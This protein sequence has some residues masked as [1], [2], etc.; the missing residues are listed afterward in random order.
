MKNSNKGKQAAWGRQPRAVS[1]H[2]TS[3][4]FRVGRRADTPAED[5]HRCESARACP[6][7]AAAPPLQ[8]LQQPGRHSPATDVVAID[9]SWHCRASLSPAGMTSAPRAAGVMAPIG[10]A[11][12]SAEHQGCCLAHAQGHM[13]LWTACAAGPAIALA[14]QVCGEA[15]ATVRARTE[16]G[17]DALFRAGAEAA[18]SAAMDAATS[19]LAG[20]APARFVTGL[21]RDLGARAGAPGAAPHL[22]MHA[23]SG[24]PPCFAHGRQK[25][26]CALSNSGVACC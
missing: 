13:S 3:F 10:A 20:A 7:R 4:P 21:A 1:Q 25:S 15:G 17:R 16:S 18:A 19:R 22:L 8:P 2:R 11:L 26:T 14:A 6:G 5:V 24:L 9:V 23:P 12:C